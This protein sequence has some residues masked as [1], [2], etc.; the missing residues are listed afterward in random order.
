MITPIIALANLRKRFGATVAL[1]GI[2]L[3]IEQPCIFGIVGPDGAGK[4]T[5]LRILVGLLDFD[6]DHASVL[7]YHIASQPRAIKARLGYV[8]QTFSLYPDLSVQHNLE[9]FADVHDMPR[10]KFRQ[11]AAEL[12]TIAQ[13][14]QF[15]TL[16]TSSLSGGMKQ[17]LS[18]ICALLHEPHV[19]ILDEP[20]NGVDLIA[21]GEMW[22]IL[23]QLRDVTIV[24][25]TGYLDEADR[26]DQVA[27]LYHGRIRVQNT[28]HAIKAQ[29]PWNA[30][31]LFGDIQPELLTHIQHAPWARRTQLVGETITVETALSRVE[32][33]A[34][35]HA[36]SDSELTL[37]PM[38]PTLEMVFTQLTE[39]AERTLTPH[40]N[41]PTT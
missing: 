33:Q 2:N 31:R 18:L 6:A 32:L 23:K 9:F 16:L 3:T 28:P 12:L 22:T 15:A 30:Y 24:M 29:F 7:G 8:P 14:D 36:F 10:K 35:L 21:R 13:L 39:E 25:S 5:L 37:E 17:K 4:T 1:D 11:R 19:L 27:Y 41:S 26:C 34:A 20:H 40:D 38:T